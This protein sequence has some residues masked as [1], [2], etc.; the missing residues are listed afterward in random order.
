MAEQ[1]KKPGGVDNK[2]K[3]FY[4]R[5]A[6]EAEASRCTYKSKD[7]G[8]EKD[9]FDVGASSNPTKFSKLLKNIENYIQKIDKDIQTTC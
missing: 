8:L 6:K 7:Q 5:F 2:T 3:K 1:E 4:G 9:K